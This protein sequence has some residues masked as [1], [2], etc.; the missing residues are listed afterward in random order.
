MTV[1][2][3]IDP[4]T[5]L[6]AIVGWDGARLTAAE[7]LPNEQLVHLLR[8]TD[9][10]PGL[11]AIEQ[12]ESYGMAVGREVFET[13]WWA[14]RF[15]EA[16]AHRGL[17]HRMVPRRVAKLHL[18][19]SP[20]AKDANVRQALL[21]RFGARGTKAKPGVLYGVRTHLWA[22]LAIAVSVADGAAA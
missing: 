19:K 22:A 15:A 10:V 1:V 8:G 2:T 5:A 3:A 11:L 20:R 6:S 17:P 21:D 12:I 9:L 18:C 7:I 13:V 16:H 4:G 14:G